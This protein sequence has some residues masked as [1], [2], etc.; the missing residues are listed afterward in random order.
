MLGQRRDGGDTLIEVLFAFAVLSLVI[1][2]SMSI[3]NQGALAS[4]RSLE[5]T[6]VREEVDAQATTIRFLH[7]AYVAKFGTGATYPIDTPAG[8]WVEMTKTLT[9]TSASD[10]GAATTCPAAPTNAFVV[11]GASGKYIKNVGNSII[12]ATTFA[13][14][15]YD[16]TS[17]LFT[18][19][20]G[21]W[22][23]AIRSVA[24]LDVNKKNVQFIDFH[25]RA[26]WD[27]PGNGPPMTI[28]TIVR[29]Y[30]PRG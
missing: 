17:G 1:V 21:I 12:P 30:E 10:F 13:Q 3:M 7:D 14:L 19:A 4:Q 5:T 25:I 29:L 16:D 15:S 28:G 18:N 8:Q 24:S 20:Q 9:A 26:C 2:G 11:D 23:E 6:L 22:V 27:S